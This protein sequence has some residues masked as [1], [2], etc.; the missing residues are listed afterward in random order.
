M[1]P[2]CRNGTPL[3][4]EVPKVWNTLLGGATASQDQHVR[5]KSKRFQLS[6]VRRNRRMGEEGMKLTFVGAFGITVLVIVVFLVLRALLNRSSQG[7]EQRSIEL[8]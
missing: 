5:R 4:L 8:P 1:E 6:Q 7:P 3:P 2:D